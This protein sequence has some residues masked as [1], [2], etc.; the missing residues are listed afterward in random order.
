M[1]IYKYIILFSLLSLS[2][3]EKNSH[4]IQKEIDFLRAK[5]EKLDNDE[6]KEDR[7]F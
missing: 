3:S 6:E 7:P 1:K 5:L 4:E 2:F